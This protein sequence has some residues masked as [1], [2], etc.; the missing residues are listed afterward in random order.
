M[1]LYCKILKDKMEFP[2]EE[3]QNTLFFIYSANKSYNSQ[4]SKIKILAH[5]QIRTLN[6]T[7]QNNTYQLRT[8][9]G[10]M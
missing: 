8:P 3:R 5:G 7:I 4:K 9:Q 10:A 1:I 2:R 6:Q